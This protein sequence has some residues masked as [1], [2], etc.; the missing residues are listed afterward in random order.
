MKYILATLMLCSTLANA[1]SVTMIGTP[2]MTI[3]TTEKGTVKAMLTG[4]KAFKVRC[5]FT[6]TD[7]YIT[8]DSRK[9]V[10]LFIINSGQFTIFRDE[11][12]AYIKIDNSS[13]KYIEH[14]SL[15]LVTI[16][17]YGFMTTHVNE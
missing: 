10:P 12:S 4:E 14:V 15:G 3:M 6:V 1:R 11:Y 13:N 9:G 8:W 16:T 5:I 17:Y 2:Y 7:D